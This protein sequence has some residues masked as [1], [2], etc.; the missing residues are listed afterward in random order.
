M[1]RWRR[2]RRNGW[3]TTVNIAGG[4]Y[5][6]DKVIS[7]FLRR[8]EAETA[9][10]SGKDGH[11][12][13][14][15]VASPSRQLFYKPEAAK[16]ASWHATMSVGM[17]KMISIIAPPENAQQIHTAQLPLRPAPQH[18]AI[19]R[20]ILEAVRESGVYGIPVWTLLNRAAASQ[21]PS[22]RA[23]ARS[24]R[25][26][27]WA[28]LRGLLKAGLVFR[29]RRT[30]VTAAR[31]P[32]VTARRRRSQW[33]GSTLA[34]PAQERTAISFNHLS[35]KLPDLSRPTSGAP[36]AL[37]KAQSA[38]S[39]TEVVQAASELARLPRSPRRKWTGWLS[40]GI[41]AYRGLAVRLSSGGQVYVFG[42]SRSKV[43]YM[44][45][46][47]AAV[48]DPKELWQTWGVVDARSVEPVT[49]RPARLLGSLK[50]GRRERVFQAHILNVRGHCRRRRLAFA[51][52]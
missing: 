26:A 52:P 33:A 34:E 48:G 25:L 35:P 44:T 32:R 7:E 8:A 6:T 21:S 18:D 39:A 3:L 45:H 28:R 29:F 47:D 16:S 2:W 24:L 41:R 22:C 50:A 51:S 10:Q 37:P 49:S 5:L 30:K 42:V 27:S 31:L 20:G 40:S 17:S 15:G 38:P 23:A 14:R 36:Q 1:W 19:D 13:G 4:P 11:N 43:I 12:A 9:G 46:L